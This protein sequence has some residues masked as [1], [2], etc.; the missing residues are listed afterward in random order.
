LD[1]RFN[2]G[3]TLLVVNID[4]SIATT[5]LEFATIA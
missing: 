5:A 3:R 2:V 4:E 1:V